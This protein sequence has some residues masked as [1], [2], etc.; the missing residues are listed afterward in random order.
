MAT[1]VFG[2][3]KDKHLADADALQF[4]QKC[5]F[6]FAK[7]RD[8]QEWTGLLSVQLEAATSMER[9]VPLLQSDAVGVPSRIQRDRALAS[10]VNFSPRAKYGSITAESRSL[11][12]MRG[13]FGSTR[14]FNSV[15]SRITT[16]PSLRRFPPASEKECD[17]CILRPVQK[18]SG[19]SIVLGYLQPA[20]M[21]I[22]S[23]GSQ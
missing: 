10:R 8:I 6:V 2:L 21:V 5:R 9:E 3:W 4:T 19:E 17:G 14:W 1:D 23:R 12:K 13:S 15:G 20:Q 22:R 11:S 7:N 18:S 16:R